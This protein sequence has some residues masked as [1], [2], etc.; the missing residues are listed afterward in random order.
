MSETPSN[1]SH[2]DILS[3]GFWLL[4]GDAVDISKYKEVPEKRRFIGLLAERF[5]TD[6][7]SKQSSTPY[8][9]EYI[10]NKSQLF[11]AY[12][13]QKAGDLSK[14]TSLSIK[15]GILRLFDVNGVELYSINAV[16][17][18]DTIL[19]GTGEVEAIER[20][21]KT[22]TEALREEAM[23]DSLFG[24]SVLVKYSTAGAALGLA[25]NSAV[26]MS[27]YTLNGV[28]ATADLLR[29][30]VSIKELWVKNHAG[31]MERVLLTDKILESIQGLTNGPRHVI[32]QNSLRILQSLGYVFDPVKRACTHATKIAFT[33]TVRILETTPLKELRSKY[34]ITVSEKELAKVRAGLSQTKTVVTEAGYASA[35]IAKIL[36]GGLMHAV[37]FPVF[38]SSFTKQQN[39]ANLIAGFAEWGLFTT[40]MIVGKVVGKPLGIFGKIGA[41]LVGGIIATNGG[42]YLWEKY[43]GNQEKWKMFNGLDMYS[44]K[45]SLIAHG[46]N[47][48]IPE[49]IDQLNKTDLGGLND[50]GQWSG[51]VAIPGG[52]IGKILPEGWGKHVP[53]TGGTG[54]IPDIVFIQSRVNLGVDPYEWMGG[55]FNNRNINQWN[56]EVSRHKEELLLK[57]FKLIGDYQ[58]NET[59]F[60]A[61]NLREKNMELFSD[62]L[63]VHTLNLGQSDRWKFEQ[64]QIHDAVMGMLP[65]WDKNKSPMECR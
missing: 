59:P 29:G 9:K 26:S 12:I 27:R 57:I 41:P 11:A 54:V 49:V 14:V 30:N 39:S 63:A 31:Q 55:S 44:S 50:H 8:N 43:D 51:N 33:E 40:G 36:S 24:G 25:T 21:L 16:R 42:H 32:R 34:G 18:W 22:K 47:F 3:G 48:G 5:Y 62:I 35:S 1:N 53:L 37:M 38:F 10:R 65:K 17:L 58:K 19:K 23:T 2:T 7:Y 60:S 52:N 28:G 64:I 45:R 4:S 56:I 46:L 20:N 15:D 6:S 61:K 13:E